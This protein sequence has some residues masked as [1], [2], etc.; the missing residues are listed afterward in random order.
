LNSPQLAA[1]KKV[2]ATEIEDFRAT[3]FN[4]PSAC[5]GVVYSI[6]LST[7]I[8]FQ[9]CDGRNLAMKNKQIRKVEHGVY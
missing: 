3:L 7:T 4:T 2:V 5:G 6:D 9:S 8:I 1:I